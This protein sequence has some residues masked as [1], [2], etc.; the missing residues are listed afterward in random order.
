M[1]KLQ[2]RACKNIWAVASKTLSSSMRKM[3]I[4]INPAHAQSHPGICSHCIQSTVYTNS[5]SGSD[6]PD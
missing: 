3:Q 6:G 1:C 5:V 4:Q 2:E